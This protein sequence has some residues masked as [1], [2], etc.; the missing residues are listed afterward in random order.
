[1]QEVIDKASQKSFSSL[2]KIRELCSQLYKYAMQND[3]VDKNY[4]QYLTLPKKYT[5]D[6]D[7]FT[8]LKSLKSKN[9]R[10]T[11]FPSRIA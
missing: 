9:P 4:A 11:V 8:T 6:R 7:A 2:A 1:M 10:K 3:I 5:H